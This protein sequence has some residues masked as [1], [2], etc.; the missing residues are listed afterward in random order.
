[1]HN[2]HFDRHCEPRV[3]R[4]FRCDHC[5]VTSSSQTVSTTCYLKRP[6]VLEPLFS[7]LLACSGYRQIAREA[8]L[9]RAF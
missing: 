9:R 4:R 7:R 2:G 6:E 3:I 1:M 8:R 5:G